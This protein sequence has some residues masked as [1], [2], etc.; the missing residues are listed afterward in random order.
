MFTNGPSAQSPGTTAN[1][2]VHLADVAYRAFLVWA[3]VCLLS[4]V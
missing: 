3:F 4:W 2:G 1:A